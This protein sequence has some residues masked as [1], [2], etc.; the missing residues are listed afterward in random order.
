MRCGF[1]YIYWVCCIKVLDSFIIW[2]SGEMYN[3]KCGSSL[4]LYVMFEMCYCMFDGYV[5]EVWGL[6]IV[7]FLIFFFFLELI[8]LFKFWFDIFE[9]RIVVFLI[10]M[11]LCFDFVGFI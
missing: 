6:G 11:R 4:L 10:K 9:L 8:L 5:S 2:Y 3:D 1:S 7:V